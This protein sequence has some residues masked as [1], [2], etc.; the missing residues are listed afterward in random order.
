MITPYDR[1][2]YPGRAYE[3]AHPDRL[4]TLAALYGLDP[5]P[6]AR[7]LV[8]EL[9]CSRGGHLIPMAYQYPESQFVGIDLSESSRVSARSRRLA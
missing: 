9:G 6:V 4:S 7:C 2:H 1:V 8:L 3:D 5:A